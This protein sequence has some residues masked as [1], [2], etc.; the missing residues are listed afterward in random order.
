[1]LKNMYV[2]FDSVAKESGPVF[3]CKNDG[4]ALRSFS[5]MIESNQDKEEFHLFLVGE[6]DHETNVIQSLI[7]KEIKR[8][9]I[10]DV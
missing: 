7:P 10:N 5:K 8:E 1:M 6:M 9:D 4:V 3:E 2:I